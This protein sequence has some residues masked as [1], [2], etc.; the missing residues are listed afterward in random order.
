MLCFQGMDNHNTL[1]HAFWQIFYWHFIRIIVNWVEGCLLNG[2]FSF[3]VRIFWSG[4]NWRAHLAP[5]LVPP[6]TP[7]WPRIANSCPVWYFEICSIHPEQRYTYRVLQTILMKLIL[8]CVSAEWAVLGSAKTALK[9]K[10]EIQ[11]D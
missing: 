11:I 5:V 3:L 10:Y 2:I 4:P 1:W 6:P 8:L 9:F 7:Q